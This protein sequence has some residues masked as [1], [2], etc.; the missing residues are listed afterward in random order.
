MLEFRTKI[1]H[2]LTNLVYFLRT[3]SFLIL[4]Q[5][6]YTVN[7]LKKMVFK[8]KYCIRNNEIIILFNGYELKGIPRRNI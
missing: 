7:S 1:F 2:K 5:P 8:K 3:Y 4:L 6:T